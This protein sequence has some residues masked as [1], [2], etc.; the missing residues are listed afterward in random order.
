MTVRAV[1]LV[2]CIML[3]MVVPAIASDHR[4]GTMRLLAQSSA[5]TVDP[6]I[7]YTS[8]FWQIEQAT[9]D[10]LLAFRKIGGAAGLAI[11]PDL[12][13]AVPA[14]ED[15]G[16]TYVF[17]LRQ[18]IKF[19][20]GSL[21]TV[22]DVVATF[23]RIFVVSSPTAGTFYNTI[24]GADACLKTPET[25]SLPGVVGDAKARTVTFHLTAPDPEFFDKLAV[26]HAS[27]VPHTAPSKDV[28]ITPLPGTGPYQIAANDPT[29]ELKLVRNPYFREWSHDAQPDGYPDVVLYDFGLTNTEEV[30]EVQ[31]GEADWT[32]DAPPSDRLGELGRDYASQVH[33]SLL[34]EIYYAAMN[35]N[36]PPFNDLR[37]RLALND[38]IDRAA[39]VKL[40][41]GQR[42]AAPA[43]QTLPP[44]IPGYEPYCPYGLKS[45]ASWSGPDMAHAKELVRQS[46]TAGQSVTV[47]TDDGTIGK[48]IGTY[49]AGVL[50]GLGYKA[51]THSLSGAIEYTYIQNSKNKM[52]IGVSYY[53]QDYPSPSDFLNVMYSCASFHP[54][55]DSSINISGFCD[56]GIDDTMRRAIALSITDPTAANKIWS[57]VDR[58]ITD[59][60]PAAVLFVPRQIDFVSKRVGNFNFS[61][62]DNWIITQSWVR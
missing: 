49:L 60:A 62:Q 48:S 26:Q 12:A 9:Y 45:Q 25:C 23:R 16:K 3:S 57:Q 20:D 2:A 28:G 1:A 36:E 22:D 53:A 59:Q 55:S 10:G 39:L 11:V 52:Q 29:R 15:G 38:A 40:Y 24:V 33:L 46:G 35:V 13:E 27:I 47:V 30:T 44:G 43:C 8:E 61:P 42:L 17:K 4:G 56:H 19:S 5:G 21:L 41:G 54:G 6:Q 31:N 37:V 7:N 32:F 34:T 58:R 14:P 50:N 51:T 18:G